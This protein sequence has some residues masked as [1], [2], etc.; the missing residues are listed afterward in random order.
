MVRFKILIILWGLYLFTGSGF[1]DG[2]NPAVLVFDYS[3]NNNTYNWENSLRKSFDFGRLRSNLDV[4]TS[5]TLLKKPSKRW[6]EHLRAT[7]DADYRIADDFSL[8]PFM[9]HSRNALQDRIVY[10]SELKLSAPYRRFRFLDVTPFIANKAIKR[11]G[12][13]PTGVDK[14]LGYGMSANSKPLMVLGNNMESSISYEYCDLSRIPYSQFNAR[15]GGLMLWGKTDS[16]RWGLMDAESTTRYFSSTRQEFNLGD[17]DNIVRQVKVDR[18]AEY[19]VKVTLPVD[20]IAR[21]TG[22]LSFISYYYSPKADEISISQYDNYTKGK[23]YS[24]QLEKMLAEKIKFSIGYRYG[25]GKED[26]R[27]RVLDQWLELGELSFKASAEISGDDSASFDGIV[28]VTSYYGLY[29][30]STAERDLKTQ[31][32]NFRYKHAFNRYFTGEARI[33]YN[34]FHQI[35][36]SGLNSANN[37]QNKTYLLR[38]TFDWL[39]IPGFNISQSFEIRANYII[40]DYVPNPIETPSRIFR[41]GSSET[42]FKLRLTDRFALMPVYI[43][44]YEDYGKLIW[45][46][47]YWKQATGWDRRYHNLG[48]KVSY[49]PSRKICLKPEY[50][51]ESKKEYNHVLKQS[52]QELGSERVM[53]DKRLDDLKQ[54]AAVSIVWNF[55]PAEY[56]TVSYSRRKWEV[57]EEESDVTEFVNVSVRYIF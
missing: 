13:E 48:L 49:C 42:G 57:M 2:S 56:L 35:Y 45:G 40:Y 15:L 23:S 41:R 51:W 29:E 30:I 10:T 27:G 31:I 47:N 4:S 50:S 34:N 43:Y 22:D 53:R 1:A 11:V 12:E 5:S 19:Q 14:G 46:D 26:Y 28:G 39:L 9:S 16:L 33:G 52:E 8:A 25:W 36:T 18:A 37:S 38:S 17:G 6:Q 20:F 7:L 54:I 44:R 24:L 32:Y 21:M 55:S 3:Q